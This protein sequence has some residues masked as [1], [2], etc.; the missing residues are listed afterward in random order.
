MT[1]P[2]PWKQS[3][4]QYLHD[5]F[6]DMASI[7]HDF[8]LDWYP[9]HQTL[10]YHNTEAKIVAYCA[11]EV[12]RQQDT[13]WHVYKMWSAWK[14]AL[15]EH[16]SG[17]DTQPF[18]PLTHTLIRHLAGMIDELAEPG[19]REYNI[20]IGGDVRGFHDIHAKMDELLPLQQ[21]I[22][23]DDWYYRFELIHPF[24]DGNG[25]TGKLLYNWIRGT[26]ENPVWPH[27]YFG[28]SNP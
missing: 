24:G 9:E 6:E 17:H 11:E 7:P 5:A 13:P 16:G 26:L 19:Y 18:L 20:H 28:S 8:P 10:P 12:R 15:D 23:H 4:K 2:G 21:V 27:N 25:R 22:T 3:D 1:S 14:W